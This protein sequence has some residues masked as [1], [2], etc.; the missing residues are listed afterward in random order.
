MPALPESY[1]FQAVANV[2]HRVLQNEKSGA[3]RKEPK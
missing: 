3:E 2:Q 1:C